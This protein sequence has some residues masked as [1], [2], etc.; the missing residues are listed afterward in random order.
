MTAGLPGA[1]AEAVRRHTGPIRR[2]APVGGGCIAHATRIDTASGP[3][4]LKWADGDAGR[5]F[6]AE[7]D[8]LRALASVVPHGIVVP[9]PLENQAAGEGAPGFLLTTWIEPGRP[10][11]GYGA[12][13][14]EALAALHHTEA[15]VRG[16]AGPYGF[17]SDTFIGPTP[18]PNGWAA[19]WP[20]FVRD[21]R[22]AP[23]IARVRAAGRWEPG[24]DAAA[25]RLL[26]RLG[27]LLPAQPYPSVLHGDLW[28]GNAFPASEPAPAKAGG[29][30]ALVDP[31]AC[32][33]DREAD[34]AMTELFGGFDG[35]FYAAYRSAWPLES[36]Y[37]ERREIYTLYH[38]LNHLLLFG[39]GYAAGVARVLRRRSP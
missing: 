5:T 13:F 18:Q 16:D 25:D 12:R 15:P 11:A 14:G 33:G 35:D 30:A 20:A 37:E 24:W 31:A 19:D 32:V 38:L 21:R 2:V 9:Q 7:A 8:G 1:V 26:D 27:D 29:C 34:L 17:P 36:G 4:F 3:Y 28:G 6:E 23:M 22:L 10:D 39:A